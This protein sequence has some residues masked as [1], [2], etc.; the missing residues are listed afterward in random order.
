[1]DDNTKILAVEENGQLTK[2]QIDGSLSQI[3]TIIT[4][5]LIDL[6]DANVVTLEKA[7]NIISDSITAYRKAGQNEEAEQE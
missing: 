7:L 6:E 2:I 5:V 1:M 3:M 4:A